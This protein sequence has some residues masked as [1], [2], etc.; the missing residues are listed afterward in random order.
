MSVKIKWEL[1]FRSQ[2]GV[3]G[4]ARVCGFFWAVESPIPWN[5]SNP[6]GQ[7]NVLF[8]LLLSPLFDQI[9]IAPDQFQ[10]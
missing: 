5:P 6:L 3:C 1:K 2:L 4:C 10:Y 8:L 9:V 7:G